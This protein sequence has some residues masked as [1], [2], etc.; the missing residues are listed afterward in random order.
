[1]QDGFDAGF[2]V[3]AQLGMRT[4][5]ILGILEGVLRGYESR[6]GSAVVKKQV[7]STARGGPT[8]SSKESES[9]AQKMHR[10]GQKERVLKIH[11]HALKE[12]EVQSVFGIMEDNGDREQPEAQLARKGNGVISKWEDWVRV[13]HW[14]EN[15]GALEMKEAQKKGNGDA[16][17]S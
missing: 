4:G 1:M 3:G 7:P 13:A 16:E 15:M 17:Q 12:L 10:Q 14:E 6:A 11:Q 2:P 9:E 5:T 8:A